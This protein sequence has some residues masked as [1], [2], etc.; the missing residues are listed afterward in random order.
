[1]QILAITVVLA[2]VAPVASFFS[3]SSS[4]SVRHGKELD[5]IA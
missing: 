1:M 5:E 2:T 3:S 4:R